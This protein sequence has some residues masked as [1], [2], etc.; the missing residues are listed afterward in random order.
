MSWFT[1][2]KQKKVAEWEKRNLTRFLEKNEWNIKAVCLA[3]GIDR[4]YLYKMMHKHGIERP[5]C[6]CTVKPCRH[7]N[8]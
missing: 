2:H 8:S 3:L 5:Y 1:Q 6:V 4:S 7:S